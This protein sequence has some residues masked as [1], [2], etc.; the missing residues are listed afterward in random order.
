VKNKP[1]SRV[2]GGWKPIVR[3]E[4]NSRRGRVGRGPR[5]VGQRANAQNE[6]N[7]E[8]C[9]A[10][11][12]NPQRDDCAKQSQT[13]AGWDIWGTANPERSI[14]RNKANF[15]RGGRWEPQYSSIPSFH[16]SGPMPFVQNKANL[17]PR[18]GRWGPGWSQTCKTKPIPGYAGWDGA[19]GTWAA[20]QMRKTNP[21]FRLRIEDRVAAGPPSLRPPRAHAG[22]LY[23]QTQFGPAWA[24]PGSRWTKDAKQSQ[25]WADWGI[26]GTA[27]GWSLLCETK[28]ICR[29]AGRDQQDPSRQTKPISPWKMSGEDA[30]PSIR[31]RAGS[32]RSRGQS[33]ETKPIP[34]IEPKRWMW[35]PPP[36]AGHT[37][38]TRQA[39]FRAQGLAHLPG[40]W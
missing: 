22:R 3:N 27:R 30:Q 28:P 18:T 12:P 1:N 10:G 19:W 13:W 40:I 15:G 17:A 33:C 24:G 23:K 35:N 2:S 34:G 7:L 26:W 14:V 11:T 25:T 8:R 5:G 32:T 16:H 38:G 36:Y 31:S 29:R 20:G 37:R 39:G 4:A 21:I 9:R 6:P